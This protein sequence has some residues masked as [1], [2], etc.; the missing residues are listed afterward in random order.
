LLFL[1]FCLVLFLVTV[2]LPVSTALGG[3][4]LCEFGRLYTLKAVADAQQE[5]RTMAVLQAFGTRM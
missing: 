4:A 1:F 3:V 5:G 2:R